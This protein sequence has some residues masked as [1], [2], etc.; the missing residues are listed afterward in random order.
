MSDVITYQRANFDEAAMNELCDAV[1]SPSSLD[2]TFTEGATEATAIMERLK[3]ARLISEGSHLQLGTKRITYDPD[4]RVLSISSVPLQFPS[5]GKGSLM[6][7]IGARE[8]KEDLVGPLTSVFVHVHDGELYSMQIRGGNIGAPGKLQIP[9]GFCVYD[10]HPA[11][12]ALN[13]VAE[14]VFKVDDEE[15]I[16]RAI[17]QHRLEYSLPRNQFLDIA[18]FVHGSGMIDP[19]LSYVVRADLSE[20]GSVITSTDD[21]KKFEAGLP[22]ERVGEAYTFRVPLEKTRELLEKLEPKMYGPVRRTGER[23]LDWFNKEKGTNY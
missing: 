21:L 17:E 13:E 3:K 7:A 6:E 18:P 8:E 15:A 2:L 10:V 16:A 4:S 14:E 22:S 20:T 9:A 5:Y 19:L 23:F 11:T 1:H 12:T